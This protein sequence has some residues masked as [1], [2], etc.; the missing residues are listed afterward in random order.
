MSNRH[1][2]S[3]K[4]ILAVSAC[5]VTTAFGGTSEPMTSVPMTSAPES[6][7]LTWFAGASVGYLVDYENEMYHVH[8]GRD[9]LTS[10]SLTHSAFLEVGYA[11]GLESQSARSI[12]GDFDNVPATIETGIASFDGEVEFIPVTLNYKLEGTITNS[13]KWYVGAGVGASFVDADYSLAIT[14]AFPAIGRRFSDDDLVFTGQV[15]AG[16]VWEATES[17]ELYSGLRY[18][19][20]DDPEFSSVLPGTAI[21]VELDD[22]LVEGGFRFNF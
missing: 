14:G 18:I 10:G 20:V 7:L 15:F 8:L 13:L 3:A 21:D 5:A 2:L 1:H 16:I 19:Y 4:R 11:E 9:F 17:F 12:S 22:Y 6:S